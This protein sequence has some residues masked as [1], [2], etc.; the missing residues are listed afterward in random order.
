M[1]GQ[2]QMAFY[3]IEALKNRVKTCCEELDELYASAQ[4]NLS[5][6]ERDKLANTIKKLKEIQ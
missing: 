5:F 1:D 6:E 2:I 4:M 3:T